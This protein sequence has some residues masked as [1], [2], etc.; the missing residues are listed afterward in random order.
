M[1]AILE[2]LKEYRNFLLGARI[3]IHTDHKNLMAN[4]STNDRFFCWEQKIKEFAP[5][6]QYIQ[7]HT[8][9]EADALSRLAL[10]EGNQG[11]ESMLNYPQMDPN[12]PIL[13]SYPYDLKLINKYQLLDNA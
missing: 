3:I 1:L 10:L 5:T 4:S 8:N 13:N 2:V 9:I 6:I 11:I 7:G 12:H